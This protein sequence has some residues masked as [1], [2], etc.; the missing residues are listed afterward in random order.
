LIAGTSGFVA[1]LLTL[2]DPGVTI[3]EPLDVRV[4]RRY[5]DVMASQR[6]D[7]RRT[8]DV[9]RLFA[10]NAQHP[11]LGRFLVGLASRLG[12]P[13]EGLLGGPDAFGVH[14]ARLAPALCFGVL[15]GIVVMTGSRHFGAVAGI[16]AGLATT[17][18]PRVFAHAHLATLDTI[19]TLFWV[20]SILSAASAAGARRPLL[21][22]LPAGLVWGL[23]LLTKIHAWL[24]PPL[25]AAWL[26]L[27]LGW[28]KGLVGTAI[29]G[30][31]GVT[32]FLA[33]WPWL[34]HHTAARLAD[35]LG[36]SVVRLALRV[37]YF[38]TVYLDRDVPWHYPW[39]Y[40]A[41]T[42]P[43]GL[44]LFG[45]I[46]SGAG[47]RDRR[48]DPIPIVILAAMALL[49][50][51]F[52][53]R[54]PVYDGERLFLPV[55]PLWAILVG[56]GFGIV[57]RALRRRSARI[58][59]ALVLLAQGY[60]LVALHPFGLSYYNLLVGGLRGANQLGLEPTYW[61]DAV[62][63]RLLD[64]LADRAQPGSSIALVPS[65]HHVQATAILTPRLVARGLRIQDKDAWKSADWLIVFRRTAYWPDRLPS[66]LAGMRV[67][68]LNARQDTWLAGV[69][70]RPGIPADRTNLGRSD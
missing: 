19:L 48:A 6:W 14:A 4:G 35:F 33:G 5:L 51:V 46:G 64:A 23:A 70:G 58:A 27:R 34:W 9:E 42:V 32:L 44:H 38:G 20:G 8:R 40:F 63:R 28:L 49:L 60:G 59:L 37:T 50:V 30:V 69:W 52:S 21:A 67:T 3:D 10:D 12:E 41:T 61:G 66:R 1:V 18:M 39:V 13:F 55:F 29:W 2:G 62:D 26:V 25:I 53:T 68:F 22:L 43:V 57:W 15:V 17:F 16:A 11:P 56:H 7:P 47:W 31:S 65:L 24:I 36:T 54:A 45:L